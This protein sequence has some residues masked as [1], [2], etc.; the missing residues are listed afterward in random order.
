MPVMTSFLQ[1]ISRSQKN[2]IAMATL[3][4]MKISNVNVCKQTFFVELQ[5]VRSMQ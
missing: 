1:T 4:G 5:D 2:D 3:K